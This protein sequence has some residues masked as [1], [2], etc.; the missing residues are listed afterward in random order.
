VLLGCAGSI[1]AMGVTNL[2]TETLVRGSGP[3][4]ALVLAIAAA[5][6]GLAGRGAAREV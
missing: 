5:G 2:F 6:A 3:A 4:M 1:A